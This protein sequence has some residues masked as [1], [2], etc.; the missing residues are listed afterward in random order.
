MSWT[1][2]LTGAATLLLLVCLSGCSLYTGEIR[3]CPA[4]WPQDVFNKIDE[5]KSVCLTK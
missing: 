1:L 3:Q 4:G 2:L 5:V